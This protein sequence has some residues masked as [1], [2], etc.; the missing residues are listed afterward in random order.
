M[1]DAYVL[2]AEGLGVSPEEAKLAIREC[3]GIA[4]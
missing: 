4:R 1:S 2:N 3:N